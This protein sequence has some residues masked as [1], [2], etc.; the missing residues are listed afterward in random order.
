MMEDVKV[1]IGELFQDL[2]HRDDKN[3]LKPNPEIQKFLA[4]NFKKLTGDMFT[5]PNL[6]RH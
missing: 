5:V 1:N 6:F 4:S 3:K 2:E